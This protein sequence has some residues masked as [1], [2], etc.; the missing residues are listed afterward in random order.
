M[1]FAF[2]RVVEEARLLWRDVDW[3]EFR[4]ALSEA[5]LAASILSDAQSWETSDALD[6]AYVTL[7]TI[8]A[9]IVERLVPKAKLSPFSKRW[10][11]RELTALRKLLQRLQRRAKKP[12]A[13]EEEKEEAQLQ[14]QDGAGGP[15]RIPTLVD[16]DR[17]A[18]TAEQKAEML[19]GVFFPPQPPVQLDDIDDFE[20]P[21]PEPSE[22]VVLTE[23]LDYFNSI[24]PFRAPGPSRSR[25]II[26]TKCA[27][28]LAPI[29]RR[30]IQASFTLGH[31]P[32][33]AKRY[34]TCV[35]RKPG[36][37]D[38]TKPSA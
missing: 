3:D 1:D 34:G 26:L 31:H 35:L 10:W 38:Y 27:D 22:P 8:L 6:E 33:A 25:N 37:D 20:Y 36:K 24:G 32:L 28:I 17:V 5:I 16:G 2:T 11:T 9:E 13:T 30:I 19:A 7:L 14:P 18:E 21:E 12:R 29:Y 4:A 15:S 23:V